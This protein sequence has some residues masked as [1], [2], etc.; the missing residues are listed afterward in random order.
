MA[1]GALVED[2]LSDGFVDHD[3]VALPTSPVVCEAC[4]FVCSRTSPVPGRPP[5][6]CK[7]CDG[8]LSVVRIPAAGK[9]KNSKK[10]DECPKCEGS[11]MQEFGAN[12]RNVSH[13]WDEHGYV[14]A[15]KGEKPVIRAFLEREHASP[16]FA[17]I[18]DSGQK[19]CLPFARMN[20]PGRS[21]VVVFD[22]L[23]VAVP[24][25]VSTIA[26]MCELL[27]EG[28]TKDELERGNY[29][30]RTWRDSRN[31]VSAFEAAHGRSR[32]SGWFSLALFVA[33]R[34]DEEWQRRK[35]ARE[36]VNAE[37][38]PKKTAGNRKRRNDPRAPERV[39]GDG[40]R[41]ASA[42][43]LRADPKPDAERC[44]DNHDGK[45]VGDAGDARR[46]D[47]EPAQARLPGLG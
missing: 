41:A 18:A 3:R 12:Y 28:A 37:R 40:E 27:T 33:Q 15:S 14:T 2:W 43:L 16:W 32:G 23:S 11:G 44:A 31:A 8:T 46:A 5:Q 35:D 21:G 39:P 30:P 7:V 19:H 26:A 1:R 47:P 20:G 9:G 45:R 29:Y 36:S 17:A 22:D 24:R 34:D 42:R 38:S 6:A 13:L 10:G 4:V 25:D